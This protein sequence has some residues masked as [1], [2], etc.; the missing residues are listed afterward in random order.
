MM[1]LDPR[2]IPHHILVHTHQL[3]KYEGAGIRLQLD[4]HLRLPLLA[5]VVLFVLDRTIE[6]ILGSTE[7]VTLLH[8]L[9]P[10]ERLCPPSQPI[11]RTLTVAAGEEMVLGALKVE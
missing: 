6:N 2:H 8:I 4:A 1:R 3:H 5:V 9:V 7:V 10:Q 11:A